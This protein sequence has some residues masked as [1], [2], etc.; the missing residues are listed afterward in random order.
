MNI[1]FIKKPTLFLTIV[2]RLFEI[3]IASSH[4][5]NHT[6][7]SFRSLLNANTIVFNVI[8]QT[9]NKPL[10][11]KANFKASSETVMDQGGA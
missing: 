6:C 8:S 3:N 10:K 11:A 1:Y 4:V 2:I 5:T 7:Y 9:V